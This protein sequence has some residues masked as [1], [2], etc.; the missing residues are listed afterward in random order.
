VLGTRLR[1]NN[2]VLARQISTTG[3]SRQFIR[4]KGYGLWEIRGQTTEHVIFVF[5]CNSTSGQD[6]AATMMKAD[7]VRVVLTIV[8]YFLIR[9]TLSTLALYSEPTVVSV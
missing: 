3:A 1:C 4:N 5:F 6:T 8:M 7:A 2:A 9:R